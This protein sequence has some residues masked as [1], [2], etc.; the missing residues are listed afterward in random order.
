MILPNL[1]ILT[2]L[3]KLDERE[4]KIIKFICSEKTNLEIAQLIDLRQTEKIKNA[5]YKKI[6]T[7]TNIGLFK[8]AL[9]IR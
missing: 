4:I 8:W 5:L 9:K 2:L 3:E 1:K 6:K 7:S